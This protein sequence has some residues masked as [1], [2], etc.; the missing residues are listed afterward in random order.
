[1]EW[2]AAWSITW[3][4]EWLKRRPGIER[5]SWRNVASRHKTYLLILVAAIAPALVFCWMRFTEPVY[6]GKRIS[7]WLDNWAANNQNSAVSAISAI[8]TNALPYVIRNVARNDSKFE[9]K[10]RELQ[11]KM[12]ATLQKVFPRPKPLLKPINGSNALICVGSDAIPIAIGL[13]K[14]SSPSVREAAASSIGYLRKKYAGAAQAIPALTVA[15]GDRTKEVRFFALL[16][17]RDMGP[18]ASNAVSAIRGVLANSGIP[19]QT[20]DV[21]VRAAAALALGKIGPVATNALPDLRAA[22]HEPNPYFRGQAA[23]ALWRISGDV[24]AALPVLVRDLPSV[25]GTG[26]WDWIVALGE[27]G[28]TAKSAGPMLRAELTRVGDRWVLE[29]ITN[30]LSSIEGTPFGGSKRAP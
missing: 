12:P 4:N 8:G 11:A 18:E 21:Y 22:L 9:R 26:A 25:G 15:L 14:H 23:V 17:L 5:G 19:P 16:S 3:E 10:Y 28:P 20:N 27:M 1:M 7:E 2:R 30:A 24:D 13:L 6:Q 29:Y